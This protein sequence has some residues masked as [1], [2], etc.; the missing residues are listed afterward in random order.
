MV[1][2]QYFCACICSHW[3]AIFWI[4]NILMSWDGVLDSI[5][6]CDG[7]IAISALLH[8]WSGFKL[9]TVHSQMIWDGL[10][11]FALL[12]F[13]VWSWTNKSVLCVKYGMFRFQKL[14]LLCLFW[15]I[16]WVSCLEVI[17]WLTLDAFDDIVHFSKGLILQ[18]LIFLP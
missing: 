17:W 2:R 10:T 7:S 16:I 11:L 6:L 4:T 14:T 9:L 1:A 15:S 3:L 13:A 8:Q 12:G 5:F 18:N